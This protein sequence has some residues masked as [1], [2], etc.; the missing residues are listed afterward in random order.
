[1][2]G[3]DLQRIADNMPLLLSNKVQDFVK[4]NTAWN[5]DSAALSDEQD[6][7]LQY[8]I[9]KRRSSFRIRD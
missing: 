8:S 9:P 7:E 2:V 3:M 5:V 6:S 4:K 1:M